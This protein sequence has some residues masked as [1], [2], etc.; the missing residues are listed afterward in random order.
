MTA[1]PY[2]NNSPRDEDLA[3]RGPSLRHSTRWL[4]D[5]VRVARKQPHHT[6]PTFAAWQHYWLGV[7]TSPRVRARMSARRGTVAVARGCACARVGCAGACANMG[8]GPPPPAPQHTSSNNRLAL[9]L[10]NGTQRTTRRARIGV[11]RAHAI[12]PPRPPP[13]THTHTH[14]QVTPRMCTLVLGARSTF[15]TW[16]RAR[17]CCASIGMALAP[18]HVLPG[19]RG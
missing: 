15:R 5:D 8:D 12:S 16:R 13:H 10:S 1:V 19:G 2:G 4:C 9:M 17:A 3:A 7:V 6:E 14:H 11:G 18:C